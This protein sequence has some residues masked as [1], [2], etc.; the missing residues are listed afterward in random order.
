MTNAAAVEAFFSYDKDILTLPLD[1]ATVKMK[2][3]LNKMQEGAETEDLKNKRVVM[4]SLRA[5]M[6]PELKTYLDVSKP[7]NCPEFIARVEQWVR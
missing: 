1:K 2:R 6:V 3:W 4:G 7:A 5:N